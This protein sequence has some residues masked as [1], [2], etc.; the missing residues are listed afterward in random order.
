VDIHTKN[1]VTCGPAEFLANPLARTNRQMRTRR[2]KPVKLRGGKP[3]N[4]FDNL[5]D[6]D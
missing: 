3:R 6:V 5:L 2:K 1:I 4:D